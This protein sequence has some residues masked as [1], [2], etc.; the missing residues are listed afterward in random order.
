MEKSQNILVERLGLKNEV[1]DSSKLKE[2]PDSNN[3]LEPINRLHDM[4]TKFMAN[5]GGFDRRE[6]QDWLNLFW[7]ISNGPKDKYDKVL[8]FLKMAIQKRCMVRY[9]DTFGS[10]DAMESK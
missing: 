4:L 5:H 2:L 6:I 7:F 3:P 9:R 1:Y 10:K 8:L